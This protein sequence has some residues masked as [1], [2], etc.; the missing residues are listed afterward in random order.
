MLS[1][2]LL[3]NDCHTS[4]ALVIVFVGGVWS[5]SFPL[6]FCTPLP[7]CAVLSPETQKRTASPLLRRP[8]GDNRIF[9]GK[10]VFEA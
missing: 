8:R 4:F 10:V 7:S 5:Q 6:F 1:I 2:P 3:V 9:V